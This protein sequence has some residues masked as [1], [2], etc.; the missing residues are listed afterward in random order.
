MKRKIRFLVILAIILTSS[1]F[2]IKTVSAQ[3]TY[4]SYQIF[5]DQLEPYGQW[6]NYPE[7]GY[8]WMPDVDPDFAPYST[9]GYWVMTQYGMTWVSNYSWGWA[10]F[11]YGRWNYD[12]YYG[13]FWI[14]DNEWGPAWVIWRRSIGYYGWSPMCPGS[15]ISISFK[16]T[17]N[18]YNDYWVFVRARDIDRHDIHRF[19]INRNTHE[20]IIRSS[21]VINNTYIDNSTN[22]TYVT[23]P[24]RREIQRNTGRNIQTIPIH[25]NN[26]PGQNIQDN[27][28][29]LYRPR[30]NKAENDEQKVVPTRL[31]NLDQVK[32]YPKRGSTN[33]E[34]K[35]NQLNNNSQT[36]QT[37]MNLQSRNKDNEKSLNQQPLILIE[38]RQIHELDNQNKQIKRNNDLKTMQERNYNQSDINKQNQRQNIENLKKKS[39]N[40][41]NPVKVNR[42]ENKNLR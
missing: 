12:H 5:Y 2:F 4:V 19:Y 21:T 20:R 13:W 42:K 27:Q 23:G 31:S 15:S 22:I 40:T 37:N 16:S 25:E 26:M 6:V 8:V 38:N 17:Y 39:N 41:V 28:M 11:H 36:Q 7:Y 33:P 1:V 34:N 9:N 3:G 35:N 24:D 14:P 10:P 29:H 32:Q 18:S 30:I